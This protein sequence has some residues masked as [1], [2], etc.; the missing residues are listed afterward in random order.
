MR[1]RLGGVAVLAAV[2]V[3]C[4]TT[5]VTNIEEGSCFREPDDAEQVSSVS[6]VE[7][8]EPHEYETFALVELPQGED[9]DYPGAEEVQTA[10]QDLCTAEF[11]GY[12]GLPYDESRFFIYTLS[13][14]PETWA[15]GDRE[16][17]C[18]VYE[19]DGEDV[20]TAIELTESLEGA[21]E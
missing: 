8:T 5:T 3:A 13:P 19:P 15:D 11:E 7:C 4:S 2:L 21:E 1:V 6:T 12:I 17:I 16:V 10:G 18:A 14:S 20:N 9:E